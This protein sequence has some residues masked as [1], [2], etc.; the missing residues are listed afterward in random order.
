M[1][2]PLFPLPNL[3]LFPQVAV[4]LHIFEDRYKL[5]ISRCIDQTDVFGLVLLREGAEQE[6]E[7]TIHRVGVTARIVEVERLEDHRLNILCAGESRF[8][9]IEFTGNQ[10]YWTAEVELFEDDPAEE[11][12]EDAFDRVSRLYRRAMELTSLVKEMEIPILDLPQSPLSLSYMVCY[13]LDLNS[14]RKQELLEETSTRLRLDGLVDE[15]K[16][17]ITQLEVQLSRRGL[18]HK[19][20]NNG[21]LGKRPH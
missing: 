7:E 14:N 1:E 11:E 6:S 17:V 20:S 21:N 5:M 15:L 12:L 9:V 18:S 4:P 2:I 19:A 8:R 13:V 3:V 16:T 10:P